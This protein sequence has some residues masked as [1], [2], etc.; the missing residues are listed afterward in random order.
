MCTGCGKNVKFCGGKVLRWIS[1]ILGLVK[2]CGGF[3]NRCPSLHNSKHHL[4]T[5]CYHSLLGC[6]GFC[7]F[8]C[9]LCPPQFS[10][11]ILDL[12][13]RTLPVASTAAQLAGKVTSLPKD[14]L[15]IT[16]SESSGSVYSDTN[17]MHYATVE[18]EHPYKQ[19]TVSH[20]RASSV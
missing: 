5:V 7:D 15:T 6:F 1:R 18:T 16:S 14:P 20:F 12:V 10:V 2:F 19:A 11:E 13:K 17:L 8:N 4:T 9:I 3:C